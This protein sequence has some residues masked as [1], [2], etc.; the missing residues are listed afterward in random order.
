MFLY[1]WWFL[2][3]SDVALENHYCPIISLTD[4]N[5]DDRSLLRVNHMPHDF[6]RVFSIPTHA[7]LHAAMIVTRNLYYFWIQN[8]RGKTTYNYTMNNLCFYDVGIEVS[9]KR[10]P[11]SVFLTK[12]FYNRQ[13]TYNC[14]QEQSSLF[15]PFFTLF[16]IFSFPHTVLIH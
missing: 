2:N 7:K 15:P 13:M 12:N 6:F 10:E 5:R 14:T 4:E 3:H 11:Q 1:T 9:R 8:C 16:I